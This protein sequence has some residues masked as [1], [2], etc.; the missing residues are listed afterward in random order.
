MTVTVEFDESECQMILLALA[1]LA[2]GRPGFDDAL[3]RLATTLDGSSSLSELSDSA[4]LYD[5]FKRLNA[6]RI[7]PL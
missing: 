6:D 2:L 5:E 1:C 4:V 7:K 3:R